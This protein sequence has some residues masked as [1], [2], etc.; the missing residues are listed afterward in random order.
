MPGTLLGIA[1]LEVPG[2]KPHD[3]K[4]GCIE[5]ERDIL[6]PTG[7]DSERPSGSNTGNLTR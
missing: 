1:G 4:P 5:V 3:W 7:L 2:G 6:H